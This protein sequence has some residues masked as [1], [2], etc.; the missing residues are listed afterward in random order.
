MNDKML[1]FSGK[2]VLL[3]GGGGEIGTRTA[4]LFLRQG[5][6]VVNTDAGFPVTDYPI[7]YGANPVKIALDVT[8]KQA[9]QRIVSQTIENCGRIDIVVNAAG[10]L[11]IKPFLEISEQDWDRTFAVNVKGMFFVCQEALKRMIEQKAGCFVNFASISGKVGGVLAGADYSAS[12]AAVICLTKS[13]AKLGAPHGIRANSVAPGAVYSPMLDLYYQ[14][15][16]E[17][18]KGFEQKH[19]LG[20]FGKAE[21]VAATV[22][23]LASDQAS[24]ITGACVDINGGTLMD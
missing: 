10:V 20:R 22:L 15:H 6:K 5:A 4:E 9:V 19:P 24:Y 3:T 23:F 12:K 18:M 16:A 11:N 2:T 7:D 14:D 13:L 1:D 17:E 8:D 21:E